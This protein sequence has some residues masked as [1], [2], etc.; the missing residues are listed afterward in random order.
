MIIIKLQGGLGNQMFQ[1]AFGLSLSKKLNTSLYFDVSFFKQPDS[2]LTPRIYELDLFSSPINIAGDKQINKFLRPNFIQ[3]AFNKT[4]INKSTIYRESSLRFT[5]EVFEV[6]PPIYFEGFW[7]SEKY[8]N[9]VEDLIRNV[10]IPKPAL[11]QQSQKI[12]DAITQQPNAVSIHVRRGDYVNSKA[13]NEL[14]G[15][16]SVNYFQNAIALIK[17]KIQDSRFYFFS[18]DPEWVGEHLLPVI[19][20]ATLVQHNYDAD[21]WQDMALMSK[22]KH[23]I[24]ANS[25]FSWWGAW[26]NPNKEKVVIAPATWFSTETDY[27]DSQDLLPKSWIRIPNE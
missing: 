19:D 21:S 14:H 17:E 1:Y 7:Q 16:C 13:T 26:L 23:H 27:L 9:A 18:D 3:K 8:F 20:N 6:K 22:C 15:V 24:I 25:S 10:L 2:G 11:N 4:G 12:A 5:N